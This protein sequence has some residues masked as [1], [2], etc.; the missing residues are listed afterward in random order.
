MQVNRIICQTCGEKANKHTQIENEDNIA[1][2]PNGSTS[3]WDRNSIQ[4][5]RVETE[6]EAYES[7]ES[8]ECD[9]CAEP[10]IQGVALLNQ[11]EVDICHVCFNELKNKFK[12]D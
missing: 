12:G 4:Y 7:E 5:L 10:M 9:L 1:K 2:C 11:N 3:I 8:S 6:F